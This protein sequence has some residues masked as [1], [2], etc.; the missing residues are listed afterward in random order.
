MKTI[1]LLGIVL[2][3]CVAFATD[4]RVVEFPDHYEAVCTGDAPQTPA[5]SASLASPASPQAPGQEQA[6]VQEHTFEALLAAQEQAQLANID[7]E[8]VIERSDLAMRHAEL[9]LKTQPH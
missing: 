1:I 3:P 9:W 8:V 5:S 4:C 6:V 7:G 2:V